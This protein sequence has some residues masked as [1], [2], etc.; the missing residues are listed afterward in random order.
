MTFI[1]ETTCIPKTLYE[2][3]MKAFR[4]NNKENSQRNHLLDYTLDDKDDTLAEDEEY[5]QDGMEEPD[6]YKYV[7]KTL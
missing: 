5:T 4:P 7:V 2:K 3:L 1:T 6:E